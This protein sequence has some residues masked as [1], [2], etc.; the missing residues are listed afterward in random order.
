[1]LD[2]KSWSWNHEGEI[3][4]CGYYCTWV[5]QHYL[6]F[7]SA[8]LTLPSLQWHNQATSSQCLLQSKQTLVKNDGTFS[9][10]TTKPTF[11]KWDKWYHDGYVNTMFFLYLDMGREL[12][13]SVNHF[14]S[15][16][17]L[18]RS[19]RIRTT[20]YQ[21]NSPP[22]RYWSWWVVFLVGSGPSGELS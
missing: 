14:S 4:G 5:T 2:P 20:P 19:M 6:G 7:N 22:Y 3:K 17:W 11:N 15:V 8:T 18:V 10:N 1:M 9:N 21:D 12:F 13:V 16:L